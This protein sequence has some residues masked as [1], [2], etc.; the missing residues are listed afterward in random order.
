MKYNPSEYETVDQRIKDFYK[1]FKDGRIITSIESNNDEVVIIKASIFESRED[2][3]KGLVKATGF[4]KEVRDFESK[5]KR[6][7]SAYESVNFTSWVENAETSA[8]GRALANCGR[9]GSKRASRDEMESVE[10]SLNRATAYKTNS[11]IV[12]GSGEERMATSGQIKLIE[13][14]V[15]QKMLPDVWL[16]ENG[17]ESFEKIPFSKVNTIIEGLKGSKTNPLENGYQK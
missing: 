11:S 4:A 2:Q 15:S 16:K 13:S 10:R 1:D 14:L 17:F 5:K 6:D 9:S 3:E 7:G 12:K 8:I